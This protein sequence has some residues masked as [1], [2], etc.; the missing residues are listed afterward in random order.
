MALYTLSEFVAVELPNYPI[1]YFI[2]FCSD[3]KM[4]ISKLSQAQSII[5][6]LNF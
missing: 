6:H 3:M 4:P 1:K 2:Q 5:K